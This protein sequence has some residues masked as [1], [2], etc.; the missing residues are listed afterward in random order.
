VGYHTRIVN[1]ETL[2]THANAPLSETGRLR[3]AKLVV[4]SRWPLRRAAERFSCS[5]AT[6]K[7]WAD[8]YRVAGAAGMRDLSSRPLSSPTRTRRRTE[9]RIVALRFTRRWGSHRIA[10]H[11]YLS[12]STVENVL[13]RYR[14]PLLSHIDQATGLPVRR[15]KP[16][17][18][19]HEHPGDLVHVD[20]KKLGRIPDGGG[21]RVMS[22]QQGQANRK[23]TR[24]GY[25]F[26]HHAVDD[27]SRLA[28]S[29][30]L[31]DERKETA[32][33]FWER[34]RAFF[35]AHGITVLR[36]ITDNG[37]CYRS[38]AFRDAL[39]AGVK[40]KF[41]RPYRPQTNGKVERFN[42]TLA[43]EWAYARPYQS[44]A[45]RAATYQAWLHEYNHHR[46]HGG[47]GGLSP[48]SRVHNVPKSYS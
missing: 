19:E 3:L 25:A 42:R 29:E 40:H 37:S 14:M 26:L 35:A 1:T 43:A 15:R 22:R 33:T 17:R 4:D 48:I 21:H 31:D 38:H 28:Y 11:L 2:V 46:A 44:E 13:R 36:V 20:I 8:R 23:T 27:H 9:R 45:E 7:K 18:Y 5:P 16:V 34:A 41:T 24:P 47:I 30:I 32:A 12:R 39:G 10:W 6:A